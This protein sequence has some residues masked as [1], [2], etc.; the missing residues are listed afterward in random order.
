LKI[1]LLPAGERTKMLQQVDEARDL[2]S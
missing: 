1:E 2:V